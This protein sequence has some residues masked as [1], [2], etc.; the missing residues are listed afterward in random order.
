MTRE[1]I[2][3][4]TDFT[5]ESTIGTLTHNGKHVCYI[6]EDVVRGE[7]DAKVHGKTAIP[8]GRYEIVITPSPRFK[9]DLPRLLKVPG[10]AGILIHSGNSAA[11]SEGCLITGS[12]KAKNWVSGSKVALAKLQTMLKTYLDA[13]EQCFITIR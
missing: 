11:D 10:F 9:K 6:L 13:G 5:S 3:T 8:R 12:A 7:D 2:L 4:R 1:F